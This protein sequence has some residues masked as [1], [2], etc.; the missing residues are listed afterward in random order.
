MYYTS[1]YMN[2]IG[3]YIVF[4]G[5][6]VHIGSTTFI[7]TKGECPSCI[8]LFFTIVENSYTINI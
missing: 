5:S 6:L 8:R 4:S 3:C 7:S 1:E 2:I